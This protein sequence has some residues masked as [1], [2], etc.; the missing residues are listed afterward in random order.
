MSTTNVEY[1]IS[2]RDNLS[3]QLKNTGKAIKSMDTAM[4]N[5]G[6]SLKSTF[7]QFAGIGLVVGGLKKAFDVYTSYEAQMSKVKAM[8]ETTGDE[9][10]KLTD[11]AEKLGKD[12]EFSATQAGEG[13]ELLAMAGFNTNQIMAAMPGLLN[14][15]SAGS[16]TLAQ[17]ADITSNILSGLG[18][19]A[20]ETTRA[21]DVMAKTA[22]ISN[23]DIT[24]MGEAMRQIAPTFAALNVQIEEGSALIAVLANS[25]IK[26]SDATTS[27]NTSLSRLAQPTKE[28][29]DL[30]KQLNFSIWDGNGEF[31]GFEETIRKF[32]NATK[33]MTKEQKLAATATMFGAH[34]NKQWTSLLNSQKRVLIDGKEVVL[35][36][37]DAFKYFED[38]LKNSTGTAEKVAKT[39]LDNIKGAFTMLQ[40]AVEGQ[41]I[42]IM[43]AP[44]GAIKDLINLVTLGVSN[45]EKIVAVFNP[46]ISSIKGSVQALAAPFFEIL[47]TFGA[48][49]KKTSSLTVA[50]VMFTKV[51]SYISKP[52]ILVF[53][54]ITGILRVFNAPIKNAITSQFL[55]LGSILQNIIKI[56][57]S[58]VDV[59][60]S[61]FSAGSFLGGIFTDIMDAMSNL[62]LYFAEVITFA[63]GLFNILMKFIKSDFAQVI[64]RIILTPLQLTLIALKNLWAFAASML[65]KLNDALGFSTDTKLAIDFGDS[66]GAGSKFA[67]G[68]TNGLIPS[69][70]GMATGT[71][72]AVDLTK[73]LNTDS[74]TG[75]GLGT[76]TKTEKTNA[77]SGITSTAPKTFIININNMVEDLTVATTTLTGS[78]NNVKDEIVRVFM[79]ALN[80]VS[81]QADALK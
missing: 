56:V 58:L 52:I 77:I 28:M 36:G 11:L 5:F 30:M 32:N 35:E 60:M 39:K 18:M 80:D 78:P 2:L 54:A 45:L 76:G 8:T 26:G 22:I 37:A 27:L 46:V 25:G 9:F 48:V 55:F 63:T 64:I 38:E 23:S 72:A 31:I 3:G 59:F 21:V 62:K 73:Q 10:K 53:N 14:L 79:E 34:A 65:G 57:T 69:D 41:L 43:K 42:T 67:K 47:S 16:V 19:R 17:S 68:L 70:Y 75:N 40:S 61:L 81:V 29:Q 50:F 12:T 71:D 44:G 15:A 74:G 4:S 7:M 6:S 51:V 49:S 66:E 24:D 13:M 33:G 20:E 1:V